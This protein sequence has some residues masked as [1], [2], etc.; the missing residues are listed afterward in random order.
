[1]EDILQEVEQ[2]LHHRLMVFHMVEV[3]LLVV[4]EVVTVQQQEM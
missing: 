3:M 1:M 4:A 2:E